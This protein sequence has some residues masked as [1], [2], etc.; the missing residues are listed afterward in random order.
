MA[1][2]ALFEDAGACI[3]MPSVDQGPLCKSCLPMEKRKNG[4]RVFRL[5]IRA[6]K[7]YRNVEQFEKR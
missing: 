5:S 2:T 3:L 7:S 6:S 1:P 4:L